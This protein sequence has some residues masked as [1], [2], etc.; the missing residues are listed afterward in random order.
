MQKTGENLKF[1]EGFVLCDKYIFCWRVRVAVNKRDCWIRNRQR[2]DNV[3][4]SS[5]STQKLMVWW[6]MS[7]RMEISRQVWRRHCYGTQIKRG[8]GNVCFPDWTGTLLTCVFSRTGPPRYVHSIRQCSDRKLYRSWTGSKDQFR[9]LLG[10]QIWTTL[11]SVSKTTWKIMYFE[12]IWRLFQSSKQ[13]VVK[14]LRQPREKHFKR[15]TKTS[16]VD[17]PF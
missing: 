7:K 8:Y 13:K 12:S 17:S 5:R 15:S 3:Y 6:V 9:G 10:L 11:T 14:L 4:N 16:K 1:H 2:L